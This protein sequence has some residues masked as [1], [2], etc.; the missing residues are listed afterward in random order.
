NNTKNIA[1]NAQAIVDNSK[2]I[3]E[4]NVK[5]ENNITNIAN[6]TKNIAVNAQSIVDNSK[7][8]DA[9][10]VKVDANA[11]NIA[12]N[13]TAINNVN[14]KVDG[15]KGDVA[16]LTKRVDRHDQRLDY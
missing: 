5:V 1:V 8:I 10:N 4:T 16:G 14:V 6:N 12:K 9:T 13:T 7:R 2:R 15:V 11:T 3:N